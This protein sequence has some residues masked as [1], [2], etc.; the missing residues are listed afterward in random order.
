MNVKTVPI[1]MPAKYNVWGNA[2]STGTF[3]FYHP[4]TETYIIGGLNEVTYGKKGIRFMLK[5]VDKITKCKV[6]V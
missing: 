1:L 2:G 3:M 4:S 6:V 5:I